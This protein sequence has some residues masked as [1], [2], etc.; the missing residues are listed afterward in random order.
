M[1]LKN[2][3]EVL[4]NILAMIAKAE[5]TNKREGIPMIQSQD[6][7]FFLNMEKLILQEARLRQINP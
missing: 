6:M 4:K 1:A 2:E 7:E 5:G 3:T